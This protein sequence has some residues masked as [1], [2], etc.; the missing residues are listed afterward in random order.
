MLSVLLGLTGWTL[1]SL[2]APAVQGHPL[3]ED[4]P[5]WLAILFGPVGC[6]LRWRLGVLNYSLPRPYEWLPLGTLCAN[7]LA[8]M[9]DF[10]MAALLAKR[11]SQL[12]F[13]QAS[14]VSALV[15]GCG[16]CLST[17]STW[18]AEVSVVEVTRFESLSFHPC[19]VPDSSQFV[20][21]S[22]GFSGVGRWSGSLTCVAN[23]RP[24]FSHPP[25]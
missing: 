7:L 19:T 22:N 12:T 14:V 3:P 2:I 10:G 18:V 16:G 23:T 6:L 8:C 24:L 21:H 17:V 1:G 20:I 13:V 15:T 25:P 11:G 9:L 4:Y 5:V